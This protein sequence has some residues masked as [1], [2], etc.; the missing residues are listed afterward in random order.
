VALVLGEDELARGAVQLKPLREGAGSALEAPLATAAEV[1]G[2]WF[3]QQGI[4]R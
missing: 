4:S 1:V 2:N 3:S